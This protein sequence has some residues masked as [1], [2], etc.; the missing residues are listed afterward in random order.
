MQY[1]NE[2]NTNELYHYGVLGMRWGIRRGRA[3]S[4]Y[5][6]GVK[7]LKNLDRRANELKTKS[8]KLAY[9]SAKIY[10]KGRNDEKARKLDVKARKL[11]Y[12]STKLV[13]RGK[14]FYKKME[15]EFSGVSIKNFNKEDI[16]YAKRYANRI[17]S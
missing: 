5:S 7:K 8:D 10:S 12:K 6:K 13:N 17:L 16:E 14:K 2:T 11:N 1:N 4:A 15:T 3:G 9:K